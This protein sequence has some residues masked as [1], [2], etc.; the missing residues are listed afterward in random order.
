M[1]GQVVDDF[2]TW[3][4]S[5][6]RFAFAAPIGRR[7]DF[8]VG[9]ISGRHPLTFGLVEQRQLRRVGLDRLLGF[10]VEQPIT[11]QLDPFFQIDDVALVDRALSQ[12]LRKQ[13]PEHGRVIRKVIGRWNHGLDYTGSGDEAGRQNL[14]RAIAPEVEA[15]D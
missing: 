9:L 3:Q 2:D 15:V 4:V 11:Q 14:M 10:A 13:L 8:F 12:Q 7:N 5:R 6:Q 1:L